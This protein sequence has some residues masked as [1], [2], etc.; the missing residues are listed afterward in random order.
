MECTFLADFD[1]LRDCR[2]DI[3]SQ[4]WTTPEAKAA[5]RAFFKI[6]R[7]REEIHRLNVEVRRLRTWVV[8]EEEALE[9]AVSETAASDPPLS[10]DIAERLRRCQRR[11]EVHVRVIK[12]IELTEGFSGIATF[13]RRKGHNPARLAQRTFRETTST[14]NLEDT[15]AEAVR[16]GPEEDDELVEELHAIDDFLDASVD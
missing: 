14:L 7:A 2:Q 12:A 11:T 15:E 6:S 5:T 13:G 8:D 9:A 10:H 3:R 1:L 16:R 4:Q